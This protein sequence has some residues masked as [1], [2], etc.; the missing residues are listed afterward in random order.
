MSGHS[1]TSL[2]VSDSSHP[3]EAGHLVLR[4][5]AL[6]HWIAHEPGGNRLVITGFGWLTTHVLFATIDLKTGALTLDKHQL[7]FNREWPDG[8]NGPAMPHGTI[9]SNETAGR[10]KQ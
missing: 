9:F 7:D 10:S 2:D 3:L 5:D 6:P 1:I 4:G 8:W